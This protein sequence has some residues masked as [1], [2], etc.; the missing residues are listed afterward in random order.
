MPPKHRDDL[1]DDQYFDAD[2]KL[3]RRVPAN[4]FKAD[5]SVDP[6]LIKSTCHFDENDVQK[7][8]SIVREGPDGEYASWRDA[9]HEDCADGR[10]TAGNV[11]RYCQ[12]GSLLK[13]EQGQNGASYDFIPIHDPLATCY[14]HT[15]IRSILTG[16]SDRKYAHPPKDV[17][18][19]F[20]VR[21][22][23]KLM[24]VP[25]NEPDP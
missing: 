9:L 20:R 3:F 22:A 12:V 1:Q 24:A 8:P 11:V 23:Q 6:A 16:D 15:L 19:A 7:T 13:N 4:A 2:E 21:F 10:S 18:N 5:G 17:R 25:D 14:A